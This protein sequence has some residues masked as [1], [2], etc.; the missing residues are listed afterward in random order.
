MATIR[1]SAVPIDSESK[2]WRLYGETALDAL[3]RGV[4]DDTCDL[5][6]IDAAQGFGVSA[7]EVDPHLQ[8]FKKNIGFG[9][10][11]KP[12]VCF[13][14]GFQFDPRIE[15]KGDDGKSSNPHVQL[16]RYAETRLPNGAPGSPGSDEEHDSHATPW[17]RR[18]SDDNNATEFPGL[19]VAFA[20]EAW[21][22]ELRDPTPSTLSFIRAFLNIDW[23]QGWF[24]NIYAQAYLDAE[25]AAVALAGLIDRLDQALG[26]A[27]TRKI[28]LF[29]HSLGTRTALLAL[30]H[31]AQHY[32]KTRALER[33]G[34]V[35]LLAGAASWTVGAR[36]LRDI[37]LSGA[38]HMPSFFNFPSSEDDVV[39]ILGARAALRAARDSVDL[40][41][42]RLRSF[43]RFIKGGELIGREGRPDPSIIDPSLKPYEDWVDVQLDH[44]D[45]QRWARTDHN[46]T[47]IGD[48][49]GVFEMLDHWVH[50]THPG[51]WDLYRKILYDRA[52]WTTARIRA[53]LAKYNGGSA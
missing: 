7:N 50:Y 20:Y 9:A 19:A 11:D 31:L 27:D 3:T 21:G 25:N 51:N 26:D 48:R 38:K 23:Q 28:D 42:G 13:V 30:R 15:P 53:G 44:P 18:A 29:A 35:L 16:Y 17:L 40:S 5:G 1:F 2:S 37:E 12:I 39:S 22:N 45:V 52:N 43:L 8:Q 6:A 33:V 10:P 4:R 36:A 14:H 32:P 46:I 47:L 24:R 49:K 41:T 34:N